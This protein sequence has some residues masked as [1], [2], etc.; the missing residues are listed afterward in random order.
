PTI[1]THAGARRKISQTDLS[2]ARGPLPSSNSGDGTRRRGWSQVHGATC[3]SPKTEAHSAEIVA[4]SMLPVAPW[5][6][7]RHPTATQSRAVVGLAVAGLCVDLE[8]ALHANLGALD[9]L[10]VSFV[11]RLRGLGR[12]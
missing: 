6:A 7:L 5:L 8:V 1:S 12:G 10:D 2:R 3:R 11:L 9:D 4:L